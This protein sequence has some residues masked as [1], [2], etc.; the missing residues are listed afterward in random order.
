M[1]LS[2]QMACTKESVVEMALKSPANTVF[3]FAIPATSNE[4]GDVSYL[5]AF[6]DNVWSGYI[7]RLCARPGDARATE[8]PPC[9]TNA[10]TPGADYRPATSGRHKE[11]GVA[12]GGTVIS[13]SSLSTGPD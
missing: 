2:G 5:D 10:S 13:L 3:V 9:Q 7:G 8:L 6:D 11:V 4:R 1:V 12:H